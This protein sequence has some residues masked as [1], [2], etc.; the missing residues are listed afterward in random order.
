MDDNNF[1][2]NIWK[3]VAIVF[4]VV[5]GIIASYNSYQTY[6]IVEMVTAGASPLEASCAV[7]SDDYNSTIC[8]IEA[9]KK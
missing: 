3:I 6:Q 7:S 8:V 2:I 4:V 9:Q 1:W 5:A